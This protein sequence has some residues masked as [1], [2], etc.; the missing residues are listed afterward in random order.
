MVVVVV[1]VGSIEARWPTDDSNVCRMSRLCWV[2]WVD[3]RDSS[4]IWASELK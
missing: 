4:G 1:T 3:Q 2:A